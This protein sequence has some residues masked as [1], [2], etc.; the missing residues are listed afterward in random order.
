MLLYNQR[1][2]NSTLINREEITKPVLQHI[3]VKKFTP[4]FDCVSYYDLVNSIRFGYL[5]YGMLIVQF[6]F[7][8]TKHSTDVGAWG[9][10]VYYL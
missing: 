6:L 4:D 8:D 10:T 1:T 5:A 2:Q 7:T 3:S 9:A